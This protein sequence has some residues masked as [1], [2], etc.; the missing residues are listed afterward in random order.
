LSRVLQWSPSPVFDMPSI[1]IPAMHTIPSMWTESLAA[2]T[3]QIDLLILE[4]KQILQ[5]KAMQQL[6]DQIHLFIWNSSFLSQPNCLVKCCNYPSFLHH[7][8]LTLSGN[9]NTAASRFPWFWS[10]IFSLLPFSWHKWDQLYSP[11]HNPLDCSAQ[12]CTPHQGIPN[13]HYF[14]TTSHPDLTI[15][16][17]GSQWSSWHCHEHN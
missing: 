12:C 11:F 3:Q 9:Y 13:S 4:M 2:S 14:I 5:S 10:S 8:Y 15:L 6:F 17:I 1:N 7:T 16:V